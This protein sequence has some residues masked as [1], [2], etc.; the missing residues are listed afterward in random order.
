MP[1]PPWLWYNISDVNKGIAMSMMI[2]G[3]YDALREAGVSQ[4]KARAAA[5]EV[6]TYDSRLNKIEK[7]LAVL[8]WMVG[9]NMA[10]TASIMFKLF[11]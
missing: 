1:N 5:E 8:K 11:G 10:M 6:A 2:G 4:D 3:L 9:F 7:D